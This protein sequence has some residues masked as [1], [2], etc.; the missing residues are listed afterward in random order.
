MSDRLK[1]IKSKLFVDGEVFYHGDV[2]DLFHEIDDLTAELTRLN[3]L[4][5]RLKEDTE[6]LAEYHVDAEINVMDKITG[7]TC[8]FCDF[9]FSKTIEDIPH[10]PDCLITL[11]RA[12]MKE[13]E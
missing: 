10:T 7:Y 3:A 2:Q 13:L 9:L 8:N 4:N 5:K 6:R 12:L 11:H 1:Q